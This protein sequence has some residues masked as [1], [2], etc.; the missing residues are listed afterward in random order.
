MPSEIP[1]PLLE[2]GAENWFVFRSSSW[3]P[4]TP[5]LSPRPITAWLAAAFMAIPQFRQLPP[6]IKGNPTPLLL[7]LVSVLVTVD[8][9]MT[10]TS[11]L[12]AV[13]TVCPVSEFD[14][15]EFTVF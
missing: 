10:Y 12:L 4:A 3:I 11:A 1:R 5:G 14:A 2:I 9:W 8:P 7:P 13:H 15:H 6:D